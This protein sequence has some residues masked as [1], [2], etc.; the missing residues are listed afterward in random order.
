MFA[1]NYECIK[2]ILIYLQ[3]N[4]EYTQSSAHKEINW[5]DIYTDENLC[6]IYLQEDI[7]YNIE[8]II[9]AGFVRTSIFTHNNETHEIFLCFIDDITMTGHNFLCNAQNETIW[10]SV[11]NKLSSFGKVSLPIFLKLLADEGVSLFKQLTTNT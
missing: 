3:N 7:M 2:D 4:L 11:K 5:H 6:K 9:E 1:L 8:K 10:K